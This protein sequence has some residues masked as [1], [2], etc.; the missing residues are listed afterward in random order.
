MEKL[1]MFGKIWLILLTLVL[2]LGMLTPATAST[3][4]FTGNPALDNWVR[5]GNSL[6]LGAY[7]RG[8][9]NMN[10]DVYSAGFV[11]DASNPLVGG[12]WQVGDLILGLGGVPQGALN[13]N[14]HPRMV[15]KF[16][17]EGALFSPSTTLIPPGNGFGSFS[18]GAAGSG[19]VQVDYKYNVNPE[20]PAGLSGVILK[21]N[22]VLYSPNISISTDFARVLAIFQ[23]STDY[24]LQSFEVALDLSYLI[25]QGYNPDPSLH[26]KADMAWQIGSGG[27][28]TDAYVSNVGAN[29]PVPGTLLLLGSGLIG[30]GLLRRSKTK[31]P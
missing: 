6:T 1:P 19:G 28:Y 29:V 23:E 10:F 27:A 9:G 30:L 25:R 21:P 11:L 8:A 3:I 26:G 22:T 24:V 2:C 4:G 18:L 15:A 12:N 13:D 16:G 31:Q 14:H 20:S 5:Q 7:I 17:A